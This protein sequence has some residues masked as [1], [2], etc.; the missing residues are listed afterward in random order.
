MRLWPKVRE[1]KALIIFYLMSFGHVQLLHCE[2][3]CMPVEGVG[4]MAVAA[5]GE[6]GTALLLCY[7][8]NLHK[9]KCAWKTE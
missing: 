8:T 7:H 1:S 4:L 2:D 5:K 6:N 3:N 9:P